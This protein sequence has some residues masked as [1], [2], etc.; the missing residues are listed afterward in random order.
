MEFL[1]NYQG[2]V[3]FLEYVLVIREKVCF[4]LLVCVL[5]VIQ[6]VFVLVVVS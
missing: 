5:M 2:C 1:Y 6:I 3:L 4:V